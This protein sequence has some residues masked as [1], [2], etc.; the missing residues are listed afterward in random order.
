MTYKELVSTKQNRQILNI[1][2]MG[3]LVSSKGFHYL[4]E[5]WSNLLKYCKKHNIILKL[6]VIGGSNL[7]EFEESHPLLPCSKKYGDLL[8]KY[9]GEEIN[10]S[11]FS[12]NLGN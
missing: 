3:A 10:K 6:D 5:N 7:Y 2:Y 12:W 9:L 11:V 4:A 1:G 8:Q